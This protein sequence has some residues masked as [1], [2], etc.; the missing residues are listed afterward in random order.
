LFALVSDDE[1]FGMVL[2]EAQACGLKTM[3]FSVDGMIDTGI[4]YP[5]SRDASISVRIRQILG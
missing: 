3:A 4:D 1:G 5:L 2:K